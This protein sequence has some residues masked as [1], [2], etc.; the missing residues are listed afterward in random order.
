MNWNKGCFI[1]ISIV[2]LLASKQSFTQDSLRL[3]EISKIDYGFNEDLNFGNSEIYNR[4]K[5][6][7]KRNSGGYE[8]LLLK[9]KNSYIMLSFLSTRDHM[10]GSIRYY[11]LSSGNKSWKGLFLN[12]T[13]KTDHYNF[14]IGDNFDFCNAKLK[15]VDK[16]IYK[17]SKN[18]KI[19]ELHGIIKLNS[20]TTPRYDEYNC[21]YVFVN[22]KLDYIFIANYDDVSWRPN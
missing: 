4:Y 11:S 14:K 16:K 7:V 2:F 21:R 19:I 22:N 15:G 17:E 1:I 12:Q 13:F 9:S 10:L 3:I 18:K 5:K 8:S 20:E 6:Y